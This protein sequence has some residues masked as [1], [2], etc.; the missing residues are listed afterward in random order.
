M[1]RIYIAAALIALCLTLGFVQLSSVSFAVDR[2][3]A[4]LDRTEKLV[5]E[6]KTKNA[7][8]LAKDTADEFSAYSE[9]ALYCF[10]RHDDLSAISDTLY[11][12]ED[13]LDDN[14]LKDFHE[15]CHY[16]KKQLLFIKEKEPL[17]I[18]NIL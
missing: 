11:S 14:R 5:R 18:Q 2:A 10:Y 9:S 8:Q 15:K 6:K 3:I 12:I 1:K 13:F 17:S 4:G 7:E 16:A